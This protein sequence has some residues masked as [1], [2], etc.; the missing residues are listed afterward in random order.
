ME[1]KQETNQDSSAIEP[2]NE[3]PRDVRDIADIAIPVDEC[4]IAEWSKTT[5]SRPSQVH[6]VLTIGKES[7]ESSIAISLRLKSKRATSELIKAL[8][9]HRYAVWP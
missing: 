7:E 9:R 5:K 8:Q 4:Y 3:T 1:E 6:I 2:V